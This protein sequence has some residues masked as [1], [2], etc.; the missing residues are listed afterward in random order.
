MPIFLSAELAWF[1][2]A[3]EAG[4]GAGFGAAA[5]GAALMTYGVMP[6]AF[7]TVA[8]LPVT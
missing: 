2:I 4:L 3:A 6:G 1:G 7:S 8:P 5:A